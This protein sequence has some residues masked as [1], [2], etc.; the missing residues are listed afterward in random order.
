MRMIVNWML[1]TVVIRSVR[2]YS[3]AMDTAGW[4]GL[5]A[6]TTL[7]SHDRSLLL[8]LLLSSASVPNKAAPHTAWPGR[9][10]LLAVR[11]T[12]IYR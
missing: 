4:A 7:G 5:T 8:V 11:R 2:R 3:T 9:K 10:S 1:R 6:G 12:T